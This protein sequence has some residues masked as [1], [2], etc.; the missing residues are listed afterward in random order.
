M[1]QMPQLKVVESTEPQASEARERLS[2]PAA[3]ELE[4]IRL[5]TK[6]QL[7]AYV[8]VPEMAVDHWREHRNLPY[9]RIGDAVWYRYAAVLDFLAEHTHVDNF[10]FPSAP[11]Y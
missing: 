3:G 8:G 6:K 2:K 10:L 5:L 1:S 7:A 4:A 11:D 9:V